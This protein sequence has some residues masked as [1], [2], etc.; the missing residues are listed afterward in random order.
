MAMVATFPL[1][2]QRSVAALSA[3][4][5]ACLLPSFGVAFEGGGGMGGMGGGGG[6]DSAGLPA[7]VVPC[8]HLQQQ[9][10]L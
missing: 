3:I 8:W 4:I 9:D 5:T 7:L 10:Q 6:G 1:F 2:K